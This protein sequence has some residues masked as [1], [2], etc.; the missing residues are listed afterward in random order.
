MEMNT[1]DFVPPAT[2]DL[3]LIMR[4]GKEH[5]KSVTVKCETIPILV[6]CS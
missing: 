3:F 5:E 6:P 2:K 4:N 1:M